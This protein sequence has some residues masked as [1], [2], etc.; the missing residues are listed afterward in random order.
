M[1]RSTPELGANGDKMIDERHGIEGFLRRRF[2]LGVAFGV[3]ITAIFI[4]VNDGS[5]VLN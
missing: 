2:L 5:K 3:L 1:S 4:A